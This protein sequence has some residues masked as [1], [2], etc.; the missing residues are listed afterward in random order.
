MTSEVSKSAT[1][2]GTTSSTAECSPRALFAA[3]IEQSATPKPTI[4]LPASPMYIFA[5]GRLTPRNAIAAPPRGAATTAD[6]GTSTAIAMT[7]RAATMAARPSMLSSM[8]NELVRP[9]I[10]RI[11]N[12]A[13]SPTESVTCQENPSATAVQARVTSPTSFTHTGR[14]LMSSTRPI[15]V[16]QA[17]MITTDHHSGRSQSMAALSPASIARPPRYGTG[18]VWI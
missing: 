8:L 3:V 18:S 1:A 4:K 15:A 13:L 11:E 12:P 5:A 16:M 6:V 10:H 7:E 9:T 2:T 14:Y 17:N